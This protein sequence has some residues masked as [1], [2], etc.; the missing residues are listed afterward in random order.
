MTLSFM[1]VDLNYDSG[2]YC[3][4]VTNLFRFEVSC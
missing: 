1:D 4:K 2:G 3:K